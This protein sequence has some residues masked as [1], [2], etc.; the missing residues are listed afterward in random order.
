[1]MA[2]GDQGKFSLKIEFDKSTSI[3]QNN[4]ISQ[5]IESYI[6]QQPEA[7]S[8]FSNIGGPGTGIESLSGLVNKTEFTNQA[9]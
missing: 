5:N 9:K 8:V 7:A 6:L 3:Q 1:M 2:T 4:I